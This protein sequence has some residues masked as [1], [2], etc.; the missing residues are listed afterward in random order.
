MAVAKRSTSSS[1]VSHD[2]IQRTSPVRSSHI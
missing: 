2:V 1:V